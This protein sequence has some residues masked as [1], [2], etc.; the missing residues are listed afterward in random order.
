MKK[1]LIQIPTS[2]SLPNLASTFSPCNNKK[3]LPS[4]RGEVERSRYLV[5]M[6]SENYWSYVKNEKGHYV[7]MT[8]EGYGSCTPEDVLQRFCDEMSIKEQK[9]LSKRIEETQDAFD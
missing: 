9:A 1:G 6:V 8:L 4:S 2:T 5:A 3:W 7:R